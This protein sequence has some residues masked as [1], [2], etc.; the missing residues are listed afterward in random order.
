MRVCAMEKR[1]AIDECFKSRNFGTEKKANRN[2]IG[3]LLRE[4]RV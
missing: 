2:S 1:S 4:L 3:N